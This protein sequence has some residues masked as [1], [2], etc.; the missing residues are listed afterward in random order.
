MHR[1][2]Q[3]GPAYDDDQAQEPI[4]A[5]DALRPEEGVPVMLGTIVIFRP[6]LPCCLCRVAVAA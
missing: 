3:R 5:Q 4:V 1:G 6:P 2:D